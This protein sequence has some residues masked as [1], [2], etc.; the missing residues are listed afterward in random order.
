MI[1]K[2]LDYINGIK[3]GSILAGK[4][5]RLAIDRHLSDLDK[6]GAEDFPYYFDQGEA[7]RV[8]D[9]YTMF[10]FSKGREAG[11]PFDIMPWWA[12]IVYMAYGWRRIGGGKRF[13]KVY[14]KVGRGNAKTANL[15]T[16]GI[17]GFLFDGVDDPEVYWVATKKDQAKIGW[18]RQRLAMEYLLTDYPELAALVHIPKGRTSTRVSR[19]NS[20][21]WVSYVGRDSKSED[22]ASPT[23]L[24]VDEFHA[25]DNT[26]LLDVYESGMVKV[27]DP[28]TWTITTAGH[29]PMG[30]N[31]DFLRACKIMLS[32]IGRNDE[33]LAFIYELD[34]ED[35][36]RDQTA[37]AKANPG[38]GI[39]LTMTGLLTEYNKID[40]QG[41]SKE[42]DFRVKNLNYEH[43]SN[44][45]WIADNTWMKG[46]EAFNVSDLIGRNCWAGMDLANT[47]DF[48]AFALYFPPQFEGDKAY[49]IPMFWIPQDSVDKH[50]NKRP[51]VMQ[52][53][54]DGHLKLTPGNVTDYD[55]MLADI[56]A[57]CEPFSPVSLAFDKA[58]S[59]Y[60]VP[61][62]MENGI[63][64]EPY[65]QSPIWL[66]PPAKYIERLCLSESLIHAGHPVLRWNM[67]NVTMAITSVGNYY[68]SKGKSADKIDGLAALLN[69]CGQWLKDAGEPK[70]LSYLFEEDIIYLRK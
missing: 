35:D 22:G 52:W 43:A 9:L 47:N 38:L 19:T 14:C 44:E 42:I 16:I 11:Q 65:P 6:V 37:W 32:G 60:L 45:G 12:C 25:W 51:F 21:S 1:Q 26:D 54:R 7:E 34:E 5:V 30:P 67:A 2:A 36:W 70:A 27:E 28:M 24:L 46:A 17:I 23:L 64:C 63:T 68:P 4:W 20:L 39:S 8:L 69:A 33:L 18:D 41:T 50:M 62:L 61:R 58:L 10:R 57:M 59:S 55:I 13:R 49:C 3:D 56:V 15:V 48:N 31:S 53:V 40:T 29:N 66:T